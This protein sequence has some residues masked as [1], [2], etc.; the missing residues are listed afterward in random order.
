MSLCLPG[1]KFYSYDL[2][3]CQRIDIF[4]DYI[5]LCFVISLHILKFKLT[6]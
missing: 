1:N 6:N 5:Y 2:D 4:R 3:L